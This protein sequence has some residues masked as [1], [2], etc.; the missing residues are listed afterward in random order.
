MFTAMFNIGSD[1]LQKNS[2]RKVVQNQKLRGKKIKLLRR[3]C[4]QIQFI[5]CNSSY[6][7]SLLDFMD[8]WILEKKSK[9]GAGISA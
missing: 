8:D 1:S 4:L 7:K 6:L 2:F 3:I 5:L 9:I